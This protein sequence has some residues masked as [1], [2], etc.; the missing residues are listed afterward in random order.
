MAVERAKARCAVLVG[1]QGSGKT[2]LLESILFRTGAILRQ[3]RIPEGNT[4]GDSSTEARAREMSVEPNFAHCS[5]LGEPWFFVDYPG[6][7]E[8]SQDSLNLIMA[9]DIVIVVAEPDDSRSFVLSN[10]LRFL[11]DHDIPHI[12]FINKMDESETPV[13]VVLEAFRGVSSRP[14]ILRQVPIR[15]DG[16]VVGA[17]DLVS[18]RA[19]RYREREPSERI[20][21]PESVA[22]RE[23]EAREGML[24][25][26]SDFD[27]E[28]LEQ[29]LEDVVPPTETIY[30]SMTDDL[31]KDLIVEVMLGAASHGNGVERLLKALRHECPSVE[32]TAE[33][34]G[35]PQS[36]AFSAAVFKTMHLPH[37]GKMS[38]SRV[39]RG[40]L[41]DGDTIAGHRISGLLS[42]MGG[43][44]ERTSEAKAGDVVAIP[45][46]ENL[47]TGDFITAG[48]KA[49]E[50]P[51][52]GI[53][54]LPPVYALALNAQ[55]Q[56]E[57]VKLS[58]SLEKLLEEDPSLSI[59]H[60]E[61]TGEFVLRGQG[62]IHLQLA[63]A[64]LDDRFNVKV[65]TAH[66]KTTY[67]ETIR[68]TTDKHARHKKQS[69]GHGQ[70]ADIRVRIKPLER[71]E[72]FRFEDEITGGVV[73]RQ[74]IPA[75]EHG[76]QDALGRGPLGFPVVDLAV[77]LYDG[78]HHSVDSSEMAFK[79]AGRLSMTE[80]LP[81]CEPVLLEPIFETLIDVPNLF[82]NKVHGLV[83][84]RRGQVLEFDARPGWTGWDRVR[85]LLPEVALRDLIVE[86]RSLSHGAASYSTRFD[87]YQELHGKDAERVIE[88]R[89]HE[90][91]A[92]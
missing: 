41:K 6:N 86:L 87:H 64:R 16:K 12:L 91:A 18:E 13:R 80:G 14:L 71:S 68:G 83:S 26:L 5:Y 30:R 22:E 49:E 77:T 25:A 65:L 27:D 2:T 23:A 51:L 36:E 42:L 53:E 47:Q 88:E 52:P 67:K 78:Q 21:I 37:T 46:L 17:V 56:Q 82:T 38:I 20:E 28:L 90:S 89:K 8:L 81:D 66:P 39:L 40:S 72:G 54:L 48:G 70:F 59:E 62:E 69:G 61:A 58:T 29:L 10:Y 85:A 45:R 35:I 44:T 79:I 73:P 34:L 31:H 19:W 75:V 24:E 76:V 63:A 84:S 32:E 3:G 50:N 43:N 33:R 55:N 9:A 60:R 57:E 92:A 11:D 7:I 15:E 1:P 74:Y 4:V